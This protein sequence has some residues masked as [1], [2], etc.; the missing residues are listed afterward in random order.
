MKA[1]RQSVRVAV[2]TS[3]AVSPR[4]FPWHWV[5]A[6]VA[7]L[8]LVFWAY[9][10]AL[11]GPFVFD[12]AGL[13]FSH[14]E[15]DSSLKAWIGS[16]AR[17]LLLFSYWLN[18]QIDRD[19]PYSYHVVGV[20]IHT[21]ASGLIFLIVRRLLEWS[22]S[23]P[24]S[25]TLLAGFAGAVFL[26]HPVQTES[27]AYIA[28]RS[29]SLS[30]MLAFASFTVF[31]YRRHSAIRWGESL[32]VLALFLAA[33]LSKEQTMALPALLLFTD[34]WWNPGFS[35]SGIRANWRLYLTSA[36]GALA[37]GIVIWR[38]V[39]AHAET[40]GFNL[41]D[42]TWYQYFFTQCRALFVYI[43]IF[44]WPS[45]LDADWDFPI[46]RTLLD[47]GAVVGLAI[48]ITLAV[49][50]WIYRRRFPLAAYGF[51]IY[52]LL[53]APTSS[54]LPIQDAVAERR[55]YFSMLG[56]LL[57][58]IDF[59]GR[60]RISHRALAGACAAVV[61][62]AAL[63]THARAEIWAD[64]ARLWED[65]ARKSPGKFRAHFQL[66]FAYYE[67]QRFEPAVEEFQKA[68]HSRGIDPRLRYNMLIDWALSLDGL[69]R[70][71]LAIDKLR[72]ATA[73][74]PYSV[75]AYSQMGMI[76]AKQSQW[77][78]ALAALDKAQGLDD[79]FVMTYVY[80]GQILE[81]TGQPA[82]AVQQF[83]RAL[84]IDPSNQ[85]AQRELA[86]LGMAPGGGR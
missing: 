59:M 31:L 38:I 24:A 34:Y 72:E 19:D 11:H 32:A 64:P 40:A 20:L 45:S 14:P 9:G 22:N 21:I 1:K 76:Y 70:P 58:A 50:A 53:M 85:S 29:E 86:R 13:P 41:K 69:G 3:P 80:R 73:L 67:Q 28:G 63:A 56:L 26:L 57:I 39:M 17:S 79:R 68:D 18:A 36:L 43:G 75:H 74:E 16:G 61:L 54:F 66:G 47:R 52:L 83:Q 49:L 23:D 10:P 46:S 6:G 51:F 12:D 37:G 2:V 77:E 82:A 15:F 42:F 5:G 30:D 44:L 48:L 27:V 55:L 71:A 33:L 62:A 4:P 35:F 25:R 81:L 65:T 7:A 8:C 60:L 84:A 78:P